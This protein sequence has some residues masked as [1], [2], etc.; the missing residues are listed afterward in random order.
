MSDL[1]RSASSFRAVVAGSDG[2]PMTEPTIA[3]ERIAKLIALFHGSQIKFCR[4][5]ISYTIAM[6][7]LNTDSGWSDVADR[8]A[9]RNWRD[10]LVAARAII[11][12]NNDR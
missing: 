6:L 8:Y 10:Y 11:E 12:M 7:A 3:E 9:D 1:P 5:G 4:G 2:A